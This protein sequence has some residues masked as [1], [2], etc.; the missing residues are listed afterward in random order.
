KFEQEFP[1]DDRPQAQQ[2]IS[3]ALIHNE[4][5]REGVLQFSLPQ[6]SH[7]VVMQ[8]EQVGLQNHSMNNGAHLSLNHENIVMNP[9]GIPES[10]VLTSSI[11][12]TEPNSLGNQFLAPADH[13]VTSQDVHNSHVM[14]DDVKTVYGTTQ[15]ISGQVLPASQFVT[16]EGTFYIEAGDIIN[17]GTVVLNS[18]PGAFFFDLSGEGHLLNVPMSGNVAHD[19][20]IVAG[21][22]ALNVTSNASEPIYSTSGDPNS[23]NAISFSVRNAQQPSQML[24]APPVATGFSNPEIVNQNILSSVHS[25]MPSDTVEAGSS[26]SSIGTSSTVQY[27]HIDGSEMGLFTPSLAVEPAPA[28]PEQPPPSVPIIEAPEQ[29]KDPPAEAKSQP[30]V[31]NPAKCS[32]CGKE[33]AV[34]STLKQHMRTNHSG[35]HFCIIC[36]DAFTTKEHLIT[37]KM[38]HK[39]THSCPECFL[40]FV[41]KAALNQHRQKVHKISGLPTSK[42]VSRSFS[43][44]RCKASFFQL[45]DL[46]RHLL[47]HTG[48]KP[49]K[50]K[51]CGACFTRKSSLN[52]HERIHTGEKPYSCLDCDLSFAYRY[53]INRHRAIHKEED[54]SNFSMPYVFN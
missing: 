18:S 6:L 43:C 26:S 8:G 30:I 54:Q 52:K 11:N 23:S 9:S 24:D 47:G 42:K 2:E 33:F 39:A 41:S 46:N 7:T 48:E 17:N 51:Q 20:V 32:V 31:I 53:Q 25:S 13:I 27:A 15:I 10:Q 28:A 44:N 19:S 45:S 3:N 21:S 14:Q 5:C 34:K 38:Q 36:F 22:S 1:T 35:L 37:H 29:F 16:S 49:F 4:G 40:L 12:T 50:C